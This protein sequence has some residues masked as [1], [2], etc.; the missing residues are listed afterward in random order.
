LEYVDRWRDHTMR[1]ALAELAAEAQA[2]V[3]AAPS[4]SRW[5]PRL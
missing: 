4:C 2:Y 5:A 1:S 3:R